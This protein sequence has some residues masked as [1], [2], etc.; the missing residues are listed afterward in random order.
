VNFCESSAPIPLRR[1]EN[2]LN[3]RLT[4]YP[5]ILQKCLEEDSTEEEG[6]EITVKEVTNKGGMKIL[7]E[8]GKDKTDQGEAVAAGVEEA[9]VILQDLKAETLVCFIFY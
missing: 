8:A 6:G 3:A 4:S 7:M 9:E 2:I 1:F 5:F